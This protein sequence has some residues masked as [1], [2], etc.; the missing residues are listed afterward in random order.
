[1]LKLV[2]ENDLFNICRVFLLRVLPL[3]TYSV[4]MS[5]FYSVKFMYIIM[6]FIFETEYIGCFLLAG[7]D[8]LLVQD[9]KDEHC[10]LNGLV[11]HSE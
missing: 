7:N 9:W 8:N 5:T 3:D 2:F 6:G 10:T 11:V 1:M 4:T